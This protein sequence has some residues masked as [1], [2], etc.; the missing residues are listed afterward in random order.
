MLYFIVSFFLP[1]LTPT[2]LNGPEESRNGEVNHQ[3]GRSALSSVEL[4]F[5]LFK[6][7]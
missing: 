1:S 7:V 3:T 5:C 4:C 6:P 2:S